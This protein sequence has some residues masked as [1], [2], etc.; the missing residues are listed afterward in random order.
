MITITIHRGTHQIGGCGTELRTEKS[1]I[2]IDLGT[3]LPQ[4]DGT[5]AAE[6]L[7]IPGLTEGKPDCD[8][9]FF[10]HYHGDH[11][12][13]IHRI[14][15][16]IPIY[17]GQAAQ[18]ISRILN[19]HLQKAYLSHPEGFSD[20]NSHIQALNRVRTFADG[21]KMKIGDIQITPCRVDHSAFDSYFFLIEAG[22]V[23]VL[24]TGDFRDH[25]Y[26][27]PMLADTL[28]EIGHADVLICE[29]TMLTRT[30]EA[31]MTEQEL[32]EKA[33]RIMN[34]HRNVFV[35]CSSTNIDRIRAFYQAKNRSDPPA[36]PAVC[37]LYQ[38]VILN[39]AEEFSPI[40]GSAYRFDWI[41]PD[42][43]W[44]TKLHKWMRDNGFVMFVRAN[45]RFRR[46]M[47]PYRGNCK[48]IYS[49]WNGYLQR[50][51]MASFLD[52]YDWEALHT[53]GHADRETIRALI[54]TVQPKAIIPL[55]TEAPEAFLELAGN[56][57]VLLTKDKETIRYE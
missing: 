52:G 40:K 15:P 41:V 10:T 2:F 9:V 48:V 49:M 11:I 8:G 55:H 3:E 54:E 21:Q 13:N 36:R 38:K 30:G 12:G 47:E 16:E 34:R 57:E 28:A 29:G 31:V 35:L 37:D 14:L 56:A 33:R 24:H 42:A 46:I 23:R 45:D 22:E 18:K 6:T 32:E 44:N 20:R 50:P 5:Q 39:A 43:D 17:M 1:R 25:G 27:G 26:T 53:S 4:P 51:E 7:S 19:E